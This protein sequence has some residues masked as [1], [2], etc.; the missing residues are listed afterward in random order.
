MK[1]LFHRK[2]QTIMD[3]DAWKQKHGR[4]TEKRDFENRLSISDHLFFQN[5]SRHVFKEHHEQRQSNE[6]EQNH[7]LIGNVSPNEEIL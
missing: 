5:S 1:K 3:L 4:K 6:N 2:Q 7:L